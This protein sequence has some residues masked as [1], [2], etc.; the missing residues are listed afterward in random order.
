MITMKELAQAVNTYAPRL[1]EEDKVKFS[2]YLHNQYAQE[3]NLDELN[4]STE[5]RMYREAN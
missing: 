4:L 5:W 1:D 2:M 3:N